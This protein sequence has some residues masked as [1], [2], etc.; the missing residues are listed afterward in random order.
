MFGFSAH[1]R[2]ICVMRTCA[3]YY[4]LYVQI[5]FMYLFYTYKRSPLYTYIGW[6]LLGE[7]Y[8]GGLAP[9]NPPCKLW[10]HNSDT[11]MA[12]YTHTSDIC[13]LKVSYKVPI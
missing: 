8:S 3:A 5:S 6:V 9:M 12:I 11:N 7:K 2:D 4:L 13:T 1:F 10:G